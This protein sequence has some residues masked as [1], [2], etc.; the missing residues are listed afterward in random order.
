MFD[1]IP[2]LFF[3]A[4][5]W[6]SIAGV[7]IALYYF[8]NKQSLPRKPGKF[9]IKHKKRIRLIS[10]IFLILILIFSWSM[11]FYFSIST[12]RG[13]PKDLPQTSEFIRLPLEVF[14]I[15]SIFQ[16]GWTVLC[17]GSLSY[18]YLN[19]T[20]AKRLILLVLSLMPIVLTA[21]LLVLIPPEKPDDLWLTL[22][23]GLLSLTWCWLFNGPAIIAGKH[24]FYLAWY[25]SRA[26]RITSSEHPDWWQI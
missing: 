17:I 13:L 6:V 8:F 1:K 14:L 5:F 26:L 11:T 20:K 24:I 21:L 25:I 23:I 16:W 12:N 9:F 19:L 4:W 7:F 18:F 10:D 22:R 2:N 15:M 3:N